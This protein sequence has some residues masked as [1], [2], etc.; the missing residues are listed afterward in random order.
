[1]H[2]LWRTTAVSGVGLA[3]AGALVVLALIGRN[4]GLF[5]WFSLAASL[6]G[7]AV[8]IFAFIQGWRWSQRLAAAGSNGK[9]VAVALA[10]GGMILV[11]GIGLAGALWIVLLFFI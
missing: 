3:V 2:P 1:M 8:G 6:L 5:V 9:A 11:A 10:G 4:V 7:A